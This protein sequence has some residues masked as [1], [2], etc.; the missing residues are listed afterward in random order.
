MNDQTYY[1][2]AVLAFEQLTPVQ[3]A[4]FLSTRLRWA[5]NDAV[6]DEAYTRES[7]KIR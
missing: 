7:I 2:I 3:K 6:R 4:I 5:P 1:D